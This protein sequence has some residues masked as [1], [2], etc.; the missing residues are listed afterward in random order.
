MASSKPSQAARAGMFEEQALPALVMDAEWRICFANRA[1][2]ELFG[3]SATELEGVHVDVLVPEQ[4]REGYR[5][6]RES[7]WRSNVLLRGERIARKK[8]GQELPIHIA[9][10]RVVVEGV[11]YRITTLFDLSQQKDAEQATIDQLSSIVEHSEVGVFVIGVSEDE[12]FVFESI[13]PVTERL[14][15]LKRDQVWGRSPEQIVPAAEARRVSEHYTRAVVEGVPITYEELGDT[16]LGQRA[17]RT[18]LVPI[19]NR[20]GRVERLV[21]LAHDI[22]EQKVAEGALAAMRR[23]LSESEDR[24]K[25]AVAAS[26]QPIGISDMTSGALVE[27]NQAWERVF[28]YSREEAVGRSVAELG[29]WKG[30][31]QRARLLSLL[32][33]E[34]AFRDVQVTGVDR[35]GRTLSLVLSG[36]VIEIDGRSCIVTYVNDVTE[37]EATKRA[38]VESEELFSKAFL[39]SP[40]S[41]TIVDA[42]SGALIEVNE[43]FEKLFGRT[44]SEAVGR[45]FAQLEAWVDSEAYERAMADLS[46][47][48]SL[49][50]FPITARRTGGECR[51]C[52]MSAELIELSGGLS[53]LAIVRDVTEKLRVE[54]ANAL[55]ENQLRQAQKMDALGTLAGGIAHDFNNMLGAIVAYTDLIRLDIDQP[56]EVASH[57]DE[58]ARAGERAKNLVRQILTFSRQ[59]P[60][61]RRPL[62]LD[63]VVREAANLLRSTL[64]ATIRVVWRVDADIPSVLADPTQIHQVIMNLGT[65]AA[66]AMRAAGG[67]LTLEVQA[68]HVDTTLANTSPGL[69]VGRYARILVRDNGE[70]MTADT[71]KHMFDPFFTTKRPGEG[72]GL[73][74][75]VVH[76][77]VRDHDGAILVESTPGNG[78]SMAVYLPEHQAELVADTAERAEVVRG[79]GELVLLVDDE[80]ALCRSISGLLERIGYRVKACS[81]PARAVELLNKE[82]TAIDIVLTDLTMPGLTGVDVACEALK[83]RPEMPVL[84]M[85]GF[86]PNWSA[87]ALKEIG[88]V[89]LIAKPLSAVR[90]SESLADALARGGRRRSS[91]TFGEKRES[92]GRN[93]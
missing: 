59:Q 68:V 27:V 65:N 75:A 41:L 92:T 42:Q 10:A 29:L 17:F 81:E 33:T 13:N 31:A 47:Q 12:G 87:E 5:R 23:S 88:V 82:P 40:D 58:L 4:L 73:G 91:R 18:T 37:R 7:P 30:P 28:G 2:S 48:R 46:A 36:E 35:Q 72:T 78:T 66:H 9:V 26:Q 52:V 60:Q 39:A 62:K 89:D 38:L 83:L 19:Q 84:V 53:I 1:A 21:G 71:L 85:S 77:I 20:A 22:T 45:T 44:R 55:L 70:G 14:T 43:G 57:L 25:K 50:E 54:R 24:F 64:P 16:A 3:Y 67:Q 93:H 74:L 32:R 49:R 86:N 15:G 51:E 61:R 90:L 56:R 34:G 80:E 63:G 79:H 76:G 8:D 69:Q 6:L 11:D